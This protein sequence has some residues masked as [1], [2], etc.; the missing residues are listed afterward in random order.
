MSCLTNYHCHDHEYVLT[1]IK[2]RGKIIVLL[3]CLSTF[4]LFIDFIPIKVREISLLGI[5]ISSNA[6][7]LRWTTVLMEIYLH[8]TLLITHLAAGTSQKELMPT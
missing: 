6:S 5:A 4:H 1:Y 7:Y 8:I 3:V 2:E